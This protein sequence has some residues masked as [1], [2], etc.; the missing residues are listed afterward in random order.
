MCQLFSGRVN[1]MGGQSRKFYRDISN[2]T[3][4]EILWTG[5]SSK[6]WWTNLLSFIPGQSSL[7]KVIDRTKLDSL[8]LDIGAQ[9][10]CG[11]YFVPN[12]KV[13]EILADVRRTRG[14]N[15]EGILKKER[16]Y[17]ILTIYFDSHDDDQS[18][19]IYFKKLVIG[20]D[21]DANLKRTL[22]TGQ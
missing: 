11:L 7:V 6:V 10:M 9:S 19:Q 2:N 16:N 12:Q 1:G 14:E 20:D 18:R 17:F 21:L 5:W 3:A 15:I 13:G 22:T 4:L 8:Y